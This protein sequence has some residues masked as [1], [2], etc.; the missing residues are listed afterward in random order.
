MRTATWTTPAL[1]E[2]P[3]HRFPRVQA[4][5]PERASACLAG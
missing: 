5:S 3:R 4:E 1:A 2:L